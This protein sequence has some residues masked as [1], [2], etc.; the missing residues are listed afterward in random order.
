[1]DIFIEDKPGITLEEIKIKTKKLKED[2]DIK[3]LIIDY[4]QLIKVTEKFRSRAEEL[5][6]ICKELKDLAKTLNIAIIEL[7]Q[8]NRGP[9]SRTDESKRPLVSDIKESGGIEENSDVIIILFRP[10][11]Y[12]K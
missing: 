7:A 9:E 12:T 8:I 2:N 5:S 3:A 4:V 6:Y 11:I 1:M 10:Y